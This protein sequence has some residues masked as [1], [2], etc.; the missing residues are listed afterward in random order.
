MGELRGLVSDLPRPRHLRVSLLRRMA[1]P[2]QR[3]VR[4]LN[5]WTRKQPVPLVL[6]TGSQVRFTIG[7]EPTCDMTVPDKTVSRWHASLNRDGEG[8]L[9][10][11]LGSTNGTRLN[12]W[13]VHE[14]TAVVPGDLI[15]LGAATFVVR[16]RP[17][18]AEVAAAS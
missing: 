14:P 9:L 2:W 7:R 15:S 5:R 16:D 18:R 4:A 11:D 6:P 17:G 1:R 3:A 10:A 13:R 12:G 8:W